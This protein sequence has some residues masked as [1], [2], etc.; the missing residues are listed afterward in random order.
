MQY[1]RKLY[2]LAADAY[3]E[4]LKIQE[5]AELYQCFLLA[6]KDYYGETQTNAAR[7]ALLAGY[8]NATAAYPDS[9]KWWEEY[10]QIYLDSGSSANAVK[11]VRQAGEHNVSSETLHRQWN[12]AYYAARMIGSRYE[13]ISLASVDG[14]F[15]IMRNGQWGSLSETGAEVVEPVYFQAGPV[16]ENGYI[17]FGSEEGERYLIDSRGTMEGRFTKEIDENYGY[18][19]GGIPARL[20]DRVDWCYLSPYGDEFFSG[21]EVAGRFQGGRA[22]VK[23]DGAWRLIDTTG[24]DSGTGTWD[25]IRLDETGG[26]L[27]ENRMLAK[28][29]NVWNLWDKDGKQIGALSADDVDTGRGSYIAFSRNGKWGFVNTDGEEVIK[30]TYAKAK[31]FSGGVGAVYDGAQWG[32]INAAGEI[33]IAYQYSDAGY[34][35][36]SGCCPIQSE[37]GGYWRLLKWL[38]DR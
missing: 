26:W 37:E 9:I 22:P 18:G 27:S 8:A 10:A 19:G 25:E 16:G 33:V 14:Q 17:L 13:R 29:E 7:N 30:P 6:L 21:F 20:A 4:A 3:G 23:I 1:E 24:A 12:E 2:K 34:F 35:N 31:S 38:V 28:K 15:A 32:F 5:S 11:I 36:D